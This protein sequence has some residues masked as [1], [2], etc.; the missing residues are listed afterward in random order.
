MKNLLQRVHVFGN[1]RLQ[2]GSLVLVNDVGLSQFVE[3]ALYLGQ[4]LLGLTLVRCGAQIAQSVTHGFG[5][6]AIMQTTFFCLAYS[7]EC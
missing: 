4:L 5:I 2:I 6:I 7:L 3:Q 1:G